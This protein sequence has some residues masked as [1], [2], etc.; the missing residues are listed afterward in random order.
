MFLPRTLDND[1]RGQKA[2]LWLFGLLVLVRSL[3][4]V[5]ILFDGYST[6]QRADGIP[7]TTYPAAAAQN[8]VAMF[9]LYSVARLLISLLCVIVL[10]R[11]RSGVPLMYGILLL[12]F[13]LVQLALYFVPMV[14]NRAPGT[15]V[16]R[17][18][19]ALTIVGL[20]LSLWK[21]RD[22]SSIEPGR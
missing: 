19:I 12:N 21:R 17:V 7:L 5:M 6:V 9:G 14:R 18:M 10:V 22:A 2:A 4:S 3:Q 15:L 8:I 16:T 20:V 1:Y 11:Y 13:A